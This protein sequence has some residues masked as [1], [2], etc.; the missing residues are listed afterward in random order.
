MSN[1]IP[2]PYA[3]ICPE[4]GKQPLNAYEYDRQMNRPN[5]KW[6]CPVCREEALWDDE[7]YERMTED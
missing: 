3:V 5:S 1:P 6:T 2:S 4:H 7:H